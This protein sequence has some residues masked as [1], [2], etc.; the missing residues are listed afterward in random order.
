[1]TQFLRGVERMVQSFHR[2]GLRDVGGG[3]VPFLRLPIPNNPDPEP[4]RYEDLRRIF[5][6]WLE[7]MS[8][9]EATLAK[10]DDP[11][12]TLPL[13]FGLIRLD[14]DG[15][16]KAGEEETLW[17]I[18]SRFNRQ[19]GQPEGG[20][21]VNAEKARSFVIH[22]DRGDV[23]WLRGYCHLLSA[24]AEV[25]LAHDGRELFNHSANLIFARPETP[26][27]FLRRRDAAPQEFDPIEIIDM[28]ATIHMIRM[29]VVE[30]KRMASA[31]EHLRAMIGLSR[32][33]WR[34][35]KRESDD[36]N[37]WIPNP[38]QKTVVPGVRVTEEMVR[39]W[40]EFL[41]EAEALLEGKTLVPFWRGTDKT[42]GINLRRVF[43]EPRGFDLVLWVQ[44]T[45]AAP[46]LEEGPITRPEVWQ[47]L[48]RIFRGEFIG[49]ALWFN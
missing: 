34:F 36:D 11:D 22:F 26:F 6:D 35:Y 7:D 15:D 46:Y 20:A 40:E 19:V 47:R 29:P 21:G 27:P 42:L 38:R 25:Y 48:Q 33:S 49:F 13:H 24:F 44:G 39:G 23:A 41:D 3:M 18:Y 45:E 12:V 2:Y 9:A 1:M 10:V 37:E 8:R 31:L 43:T 28:V 30:P 16:G 4:I 14:L 5:A 17:K 32:E